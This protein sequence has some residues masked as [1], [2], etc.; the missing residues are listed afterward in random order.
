VARL[1]DEPPSTDGSVVGTPAFMPPEQWHGAPTPRS[2]VY[3]LGCIL[4]ELIT[5]TPV[6]GGSL[7]QLML[8]HCE[9]LPERPSTRCFGR[10]ELDPALDRLIV[11]MLAKD[12][13]MRP[14][15]AD[16]ASELLA[17]SPPSLA[18]CLSSQAPAH[19]QPALLA[20]AG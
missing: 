6:F 15:M 2:D 17:L 7:P 14:V 10:F 9:R 1:S 4:Y 11:R 8:G 12:P 18:M 5:S 19:M 16:V 3:A 20:A 13:A